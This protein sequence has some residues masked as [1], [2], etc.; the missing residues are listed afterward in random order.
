MT[1]GAALGFGLAHYSSSEFELMAEELLMSDSVIKVSRTIRLTF[2]RM[3]VLL[4]LDYPACFLFCL[5]RYKF[6][7]FPSPHFLLE[8]ISY[9][10][11]H[12][13]IPHELG[14]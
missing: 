11:R 8:T 12:S 4:Y 7:T 1:S 3:I 10:L 13:K 9:K 5:A 14:I 2:H 6:M